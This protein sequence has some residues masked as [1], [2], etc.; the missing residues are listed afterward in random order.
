LV[1]LVATL[2]AMTLAGCSLG[3]PPDVAGLGYI[4][5]SDHVAMNVPAGW[6]AREFTGQVPLVLTAPGPD[7]P[8][9][10][11]VSVTVVPGWRHLT[12]EDM[13]EDGRPGLKRLTGF[14][15]VSEGPY[16]A[17]GG[18]QGWLV[19]FETAV[20]GRRVMQEQ[21]YLVGGGRGYLVTAGA[22]A[23]RFE[24]ARPDFDICLRSVRAGW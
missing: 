6:Q 5:R 17:A 2:A 10:P 23:D 22:A 3:L 11:N 16:A 9:R 7:E 4:D 12:L 15:L 24:A 13:V 8:G 1:I 14:Q 18:A 19:G 20:D 21:L